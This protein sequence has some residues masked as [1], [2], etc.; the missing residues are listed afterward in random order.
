MT[1]LTKNTRKED[2]AIP[3]QW[4]LLTSLG[5]KPFENKLEKGDIAYTS[6]FPFPTLFSNLSKTKIIIF[7]TF[8]LMSAK[9]FQFGLAQSFVLWVW[10]NPFLHIDSFQHIEV[11]SFRKTLW[12]KVKLL[13][14]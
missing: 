14:K 6:N 11:K 1:H 4:H 12:E 13:K 7:V 9:C 10:V 2:Y 5:Q 3:T 8:N